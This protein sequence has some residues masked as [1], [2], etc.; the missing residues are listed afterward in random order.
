[1]RK[2]LSIALLCLVVST[3]AYVG[4]LLDIEGKQKQS[5]HIDGDSEG[6]AEREK[7][8]LDLF[9]QLQKIGQLKDDGILTEMEFQ[10]LKRR[11][12]D[13]YRSPDQTD[14]DQSGSIVKYE[15]LDE[16]KSSDQTDS[17]QGELIVKYDLLGETRSANESNLIV[18]ASTPDSVT[19]IIIRQIDGKA[20]P[21]LQTNLFST[22]E[23]HTVEPGVHQLLIAPISSPLNSQ[24]VTIDVKPGVDYYLGWHESEP[25]IWKEE[26]N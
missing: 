12:L 16:Y 19:P 26:S 4:E 5:S 10:E 21:Q 22:P 6:V 13:E 11:V 18:S 1:M 15:L 17:G 24:V 20:V 7:T 3:P 9:E 2:Q 23:S 25:A 8:G 14:L